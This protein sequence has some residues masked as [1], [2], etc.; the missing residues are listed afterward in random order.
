MEA[1][2]VKSVTA[3]AFESVTAAAIHRG[4]HRYECQRFEVVTLFKTRSVV[5]DAVRQM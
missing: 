2:A 3:A 4:W 5:Q 1:A